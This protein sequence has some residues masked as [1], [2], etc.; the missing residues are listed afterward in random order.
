[1]AKKSKRQSSR[2]SSTPANLAGNS[3]AG[4]QAESGAR[5]AVFSSSARS[6]DKEFNPDYTYV[7]KDLKRIGTLAAFFFSLLIVLSFFLN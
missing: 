3:A 1:V 5:S 6:A 2:S 7:I 4:S